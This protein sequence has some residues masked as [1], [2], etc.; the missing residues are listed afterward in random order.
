[1]WTFLFATCLANTAWHDRQCVMRT[2]LCGT[3]FTCFTF[4]RCHFSILFIYSRDLNCSLYF[5]TICQHCKENFAPRTEQPF[6]T[7]C[8]FLLY[9]QQLLLCISFACQ[10]FG[11]FFF[12][13][14]FANTTYVCTCSNWNQTTNNQ[15]FINT[16]QF[17][18]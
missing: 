4:W 18:G 2:T 17:I 3:C 5:S 11:A 12:F 16:D 9:V 10:T 1:M 8:K 15:V 7:W 14:D 6:I 13:G